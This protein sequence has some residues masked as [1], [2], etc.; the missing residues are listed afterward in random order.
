MPKHAFNFPREVVE[1]VRTH[2][3][4]AIE[5]VA[6]ERYRQEPNY[7][8]A[9]VN[10]L[11]GTAYDGELGSV[12]FTSTVFDSIGRNTAESRYGAD[13]AITATISDGST[14]IR[15]AILVQAKLGAIEDQD[16]RERRALIEQI[17]KMLKLVPA[18]K[19]M[20]ILEEDGRRTP[21]IISGRRILA[22]NPYVPVELPDYFVA[23]VLTTLDGCTN[24]KVVDAVQ[25]SR[26]SRLHVKALLRGA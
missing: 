14:T 5:S 22:G 12:V 16:E 23:R 11:E 10:R 20:E 17:V 4:K 25:D 15:K 7:T 3:R 2:V 26:L 6:P 19:V 18:P 8:A 24:S 21:R 13:H 9:L 1:A